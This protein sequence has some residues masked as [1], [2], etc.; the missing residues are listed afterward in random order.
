ML[1]KE[2]KCLVGLMEG[3]KQ[4]ET[5]LYHDTIK[6]CEKKI[7][8]AGLNP[9]AY[10]ITPYEDD[11]EA[12]PIGVCLRPHGDEFCAICGSSDEDK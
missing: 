11:C 9:N 7:F 4:T 12:S 8:E 6:L 1:F 5:V 2:A 10:V 3:L